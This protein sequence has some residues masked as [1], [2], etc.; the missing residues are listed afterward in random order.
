MNLVVNA[1]DAMHKGGK[2]TIE[3]SNAEIDEAYV[4]RHVA[5]KPGDYVLLAVTDTGC[6][7]DQQTKA[8]LYEPFFTT[9]EKGKGTGL[10]LSTVYGIVKQSGGNIWVDSE[11]GVG[12]TFKVCLP[13][14]H[15]ATKAMVIKPATV[16]RR[17]TRTE[18]I[19]I[20]ED[21][22]ALR[23]VVKR[24][25]DAVG[26]TVLTAANGDEALETSAR[27]VGDIPLLLTD[28]VM[29][30]M[31]GST[32]FRELSKTRPTLKVLYMSGYTDDTIVHHDVLDAGIQFLSKPFTAAD[33]TRKV[34]ETLDGGIT[35]L[36]DENTVQAIKPTAEIQEQ[37]LDQAALRT[38]P[39]DL[40][41]KL[42][43]AVMA[44]RYEEIVEIIETIRITDHEVAAELSRMA[45]LY[46]YVRMRDLLRE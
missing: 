36:P 10:G 34:Q 40:L 8:R 28:V 16:P 5:V 33:L 11:I 29:P 46:D 45:D 25:L 35:N 31:S 30:R 32:L 3:T 41:D 20:V 1:R 12:S 4:A 15:A 14:E 7:M 21:E 37:H 19:L 17:S 44:T 2:L 43:K 26:Y 23:K 6:G 13:R 42:R 18:T 24:S 39:K 27:H 22:E 9:K 38:I